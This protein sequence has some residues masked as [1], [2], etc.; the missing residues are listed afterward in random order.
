M[1]ADLALEDKYKKL[2]QYVRS[3]LPQLEKVQILE[4]ENNQ[5]RISQSQELEHKRSVLETGYENLEKEKEKIVRE[6]N[7]IRAEK[8]KMRQIKDQFEAVMKDSRKRWEEEQSKK[9]KLIEEE[10]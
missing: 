4:E 10:K 9:D 3:I 2:Q 8:D 1:M 7:I 6:R 5:L